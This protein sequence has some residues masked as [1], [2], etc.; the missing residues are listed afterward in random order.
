M[1]RSRSHSNLERQIKH[2]AKQIELK[3]K[4]G[5]ELIKNKDRPSKVKTVYNQIL[6]FD[7][8]LEKLLDKSGDIFNNLEL[9]RRHKIQRREFFI[10]LEADWLPYIHGQTSMADQQNQTPLQS[11]AAE[12]NG[13]VPRSLGETSQ[14]CIKNQQ[15]ENQDNESK[16]SS[17]K[18]AKKAEKLAALDKEFNTKVRLRK[19]E[20]DM[21]QKELEMELHRLEEEM[22]LKPKYEKEALDARDSGS[23]DGAAPSIRSRSPFNWKSLMGKDIF[24]WLD[25]AHKFASL[26]TVVLIIQR[27]VKK[28]IESVL[29]EKTYLNPDPQAAS[30]SNSIVH[31]TSLSPMYRAVVV[32]CQS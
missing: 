6:Q 20:Y 24:G 3:E 10:N 7:I 31:R 18:R 32:S 17:E 25:Q 27:T 5:Y 1:T 19:I 13:R 8:S 4:E 21:K 15:K 22:N 28:T 16:A 30:V 29:I 26:K 11:R 9:Y 23:G 14:A 2:Y 12:P